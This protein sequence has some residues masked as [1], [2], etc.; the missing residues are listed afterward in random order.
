MHIPDTVLATLEKLER[1]SC[2]N[3]EAT[4]REWIDV[5]SDLEGQIVVG[6]L[7]TTIARAADGKSGIRIREPAEYL[8]VLELVQKSPLRDI[9]DYD[10]STEILSVSSTVPPDDARRMLEHMVQFGVTID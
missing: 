7:R 10:S 3:P 6:L 4:L 9:F 1:G 8:A 2:S 5:G